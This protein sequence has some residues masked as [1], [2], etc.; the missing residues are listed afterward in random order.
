MATVV[1]SFVS[2]IAD[3]GDSSL[4]RPSDWNDDHVV[5][6][7]SFTA[8]DDTNVTL[9]LTGDSSVA[10]VNTLTIT[11]GWTGALAPSRGGTGIGSYTVGDLVYASSGSSMSPLAAQQVGRVLI[12]QGVAT[13][14]IW[15]P[16][17]SLVVSTRDTIAVNIDCSGG[18]SYG[19][20]SQHNLT[21]VTSDSEFFCNRINVDDRENAINNDLGGIYGSWVVH[22]VG[23]TAKAGSAAAFAVQVDLDSKTST[24]A[25]NIN[26]DYIAL[27][28]VAHAGANDGGAGSSIGQG[29]GAFWGANIG[30]VATTSMA[31]NLESLIGIE[32]DIQTLST[33]NTVEGKVGILITQNAGVDVPAGGRADAALL[34]SNVSGRWREGVMFDHISGG[35]APVSTT[36]TLI[37]A[38][39]D[40]F[41]VTNGIDLNV[42]T[43]T[44][45]VFR[46]PVFA[47]D[48]SG[49]VLLSSVMALYRTGNYVG[50]TAVSSQ[51]SG[52]V[53]GNSVDPRSFYDNDAHHFR[54]QTRAG[55]PDVI[56]NGGESQLTVTATNGFLYIPTSTGVP[57]G[58]PNSHTG[59]VP[60]VFDTNGSR[61]YLYTST[62]WRAVT[63]SST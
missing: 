36:G 5:T 56:I 18:F 53:V 33:A 3:S 28:A 40:V 32:V 52:V 23:S 6:G 26:K 45:Y 11:A 8:V 51:G 46:T 44:S 16:N 41:T 48:G 12:S 63:L 49:G 30:A 54:D 35:V 19:V 43:C 9:T 29:L 2:T 57:T 15:S 34:I 21:G 27:F 24:D 7:S 25:G 4:V 22:T 47:V 13:A 20:V 58:T 10:L 50:M 62:A 39:G 60:M 37:K 14:P 1:H 38:G 55:H 59:S 31:T 17:V 42:V 61:L